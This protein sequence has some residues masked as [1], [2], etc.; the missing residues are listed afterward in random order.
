MRIVSLQRSEVPVADATLIPDP[1]SE[2]ATKGM[3]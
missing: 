3:S 1:R 2:T